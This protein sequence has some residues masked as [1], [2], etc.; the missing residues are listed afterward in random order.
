MN[1][2]TGTDPPAALPIV[3]GKFFASRRQG[4][5]VRVAL[6]SF[7]GRSI[8]DLRKFYTAPD[9]I[10]R[11][12]RKGLTISANKLAELARAINAAVAKAREIGW[13]EGQQ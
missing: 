11:P 6:D 4:E 10:S 13:I 2:S 3:V 5:F 9:G 8:I 1:T 7:E 12:T